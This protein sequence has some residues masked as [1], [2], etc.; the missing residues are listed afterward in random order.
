M[1]NYLHKKVATKISILMD[2]PQNI[3]YWKTCSKSRM[4]KYFNNKVDYGFNF[5]RFAY[6]SLNN[7]FMYEINVSH[8]R[9][10][11]LGFMF[12]NIYLYRM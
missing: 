11:T 3:P 6:L 2:S 4:K 10:L 1:Y 9:M 5:R 12:L 8:L 7:R